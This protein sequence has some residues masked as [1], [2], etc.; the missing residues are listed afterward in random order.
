MVTYTVYLKRVVEFCFFFLHCC[1]IWLINDF[2][3][4]VSY[5]WCLTFKPRNWWFG[6]FFFIDDIYQWWILCFDHIMSLEEISWRQ[7]REKRGRGSSDS[8]FKQP[9]ST[10][11]HILSK[12]K[13]LLNDVQ[14]TTLPEALHSQ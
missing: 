13:L 6:N 10:C 5:Y 11:S 14:C 8:S 2:Y 3:C 1:A 4:Y 12:D 9:I 7:K